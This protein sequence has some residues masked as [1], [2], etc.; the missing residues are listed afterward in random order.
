M[1]T[2]NSTNNTEM[3][4]RTLLGTK[5][6]GMHYVQKDNKSEDLDPEKGSVHWVSNEDTTSIDA[7][8]HFDPLPNQ[9]GVLKDMSLSLKYPEGEDTINYSRIPDSNTEMVQM[10]SVGENKEVSVIVDESKGIYSYNERPLL[11]E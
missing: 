6:I 11:A 4:M 7:K 5:A 10:K 2:G 9:M 8:V 3:A 1:Q